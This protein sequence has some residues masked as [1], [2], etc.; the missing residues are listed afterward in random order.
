[1]HLLSVAAFTVL[2]IGQ[3]GV[4]VAQ[5]PSDT[6][7]DLSTAPSRGDVV[8]EPGDRSIARHL[9]LFNSA[10]L[11]RVVSARVI[12]Q[13]PPD[14]AEE[15]RRVEHLPA[16]SPV[17]VTAE[18]QSEISGRLV[19]ADA[20]GITFA[21]NGASTAL[22]VRRAAVVEVTARVVKR[23]SKL[24]AVVGV[25]SGAFLGFLT[26]LTLSDRDCGGNCS[27]EKFLMGVSLI[28]IPVAGGI[29]GYY[30]FHGRPKVETVYRR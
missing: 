28:G 14:L 18:T 21:P 15:W 4:V 12:A 25:G 23:G 30:A 17:T 5:S 29:L 20:D 8:A 13:P 1:M 26:A 6:S 10:A 16:G 24:G 11:Q 2:T 7:A 27:D 19:S 9:P 3:M 22:T